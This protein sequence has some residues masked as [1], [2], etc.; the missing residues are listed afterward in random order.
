MH[1]AEGTEVSAFFQSDE[2]GWSD[3]IPEREEDDLPDVD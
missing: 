3:D 2:G 1:S